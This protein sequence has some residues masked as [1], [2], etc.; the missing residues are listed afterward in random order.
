MQRLFLVAV[1]ATL[2]PVAN[3]AGLVHVADIPLGG[4]SGRFDY[5][6]F[7]ARH[8]VLWLNQMGADRTLVFNPK[9][10]AVV[11]VVDGL[12][13]PTGITLVPELGLAF[14]SESRSD[15]V[16]AVSLA[17]GK[18]TARFPAGRFP[19]GSA[20][21]PEVGRLFVSNEAGGVETVIG[22]K[23]LHVE[24]TIDLGGQ[25][26]MSGW[27]PISQRVLVNV[28]TRNQIVAIDPHG[29]KI[30]ARVTLPPTCRH[31]HGLLVDAADR[32]AFVACDGNAKLL[33]LALPD[34]KP[35][36]PPLELGTDPDVL[37][38]DATRHR[39][40]VAA[41]SG[42]VALFAITDGR[43]K[44]LWRGLVGPDAHVVAIDP[45]T[46][47][48]YFPLKAVHG[49]PVLRVMRWQQNPASVVGR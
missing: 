40:V 19:D 47:D 9:T 11:G 4:P 30:V 35:V 37:A 32:L 8:D 15:H 34:L 14:V 24:A 33:A 5:A 41:E 38:L 44:P 46:G 7:D 17:T 13:R 39:L 6:T 45:S 28:Q 2:A 29:L 43:L 3:A 18:V 12:S 25:A 1:L 31:N 21:V 48:L 27:D 20:W 36:Q 42:V 49:R 23:P 16:A 10:R 26:G 22:G